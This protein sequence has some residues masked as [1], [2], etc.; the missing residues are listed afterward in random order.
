MQE[1]LWLSR[2]FINMWLNT[3]EFLAGMW[4]AVVKTVW[5]FNGNI[6]IFS[7]KTSERDSL[8]IETKFKDF[9]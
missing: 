2:V 5:K 7:L 8:D 9:V 6:I 3:M 4:H 1:G